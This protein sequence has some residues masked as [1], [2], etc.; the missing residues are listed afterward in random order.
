MAAT[1]GVLVQRIERQLSQCALWPERFPPEQWAL[2]KRVMKDARARG[3]NFA[4]GGAL[5]S[6]TYSGQWRNTK[7]ID[8]Y[9]KASDREKMLAI[10][11]DAGLADYYDEKPYDRNWIYRSWRDDLIVDVMWA[12]ANQRA[13]VDD[14]WLRG[15]EVEVEGELFRLLPPEETLWSKLYVMQRDRCDWPDAFSLLSKIGPE[16]DWRHL[17]D[18]VGE[19]APLLNGLLTVFEWIYPEGARELPT[20]LWDRLGCIRPRLAAPSEASRSRASLLDSRPWFPPAYGDS[21]PGT[22]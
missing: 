17:L 6:T 22:E 1:A 9:I 11:S 18:R 13:Q 21:E 10:L 14:G 5:A 7:D 12:M 2:Y 4:I 3:L 19:D 20:W 16:I 15:P 8:L